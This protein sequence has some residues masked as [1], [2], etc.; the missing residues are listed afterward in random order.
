MDEFLTFALGNLCASANLFFT[1]LGE[2]ASKKVTTFLN[3]TKEE[4]LNCYISDIKSSS[5]PPIEKALLIREA[6]RR[7]RKLRN[8]VSV[9]DKAFSALNHP[10]EF[11]NNLKKADQDIIH[12]I[13][14]EA[15]KVSD[16]NIQLI[17]A[18]IL[19]QTIEDDK[20]SKHLI[21]ILSNV[22]VYE[23]NLFSIICNYLVK[24]SIIEDYNKETQLATGF[25]LGSGYLYGFKIDKLKRG[26][27]SRLVN[28][29][30][31]QIQP[32]NYRYNTGNN[33][34]AVDYF[35]KRIEL[36]VNSQWIESSAFR[37]THFGEELYRCLTPDFS[38]YDE[39]Y[40]DFIK[41]TLAKQGDLIHR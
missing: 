14:D 19:K 30:L 23:A 15:E 1:N 20:I 24:F 40:Y 3:G 2:S 39:L 31:M 32:E 34:V 25:Y 4:A 36:I 6:P 7:L 5:L 27:I 26:D 29:G 16:E 10:E 22:D 13:F 12:L 35:D 11:K 21:S 28:I 37:L 9:C 38:L 41:L 8:C 33:I 18:S 17:W